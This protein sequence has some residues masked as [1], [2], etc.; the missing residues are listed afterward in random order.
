M[1]N[2]PDGATCDFCCG[3]V[4]LCVLSKCAVTGGLICLACQ[5]RPAADDV[6]PDD[7]SD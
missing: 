1:E 5:M 2:R 3:F 7:A 6:E 4:P